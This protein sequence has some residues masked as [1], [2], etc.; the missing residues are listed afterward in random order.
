VKKLVL[1]TFYELP[2]RNVSAYYSWP[3]VN[4]ERAQVARDV[5]LGH[6]MWIASFNG[7]SNLRLVYD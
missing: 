3:L 1:E 5:A 7:T 2:H 6:I 4:E